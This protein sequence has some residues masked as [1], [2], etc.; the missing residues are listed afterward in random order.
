MMRGRWRR[1]ALAAFAAALAA[2]AAPLATAETAQVQGDLVASGPTR[3]LGSNS[4]RLD[5]TGLLLQD[6]PEDLAFQLEAPE[7]QVTLVAVQTQQVRSSLGVATAPVRGDENVVA[8]VRLGSPTVGFAAPAGATAPVIRIL[9][10]AAPLSVGLEGSRELAFGHT[11]P[12]APADRD[13][14][15][16]SSAVL[17]GN[18]TRPSGDPAYVAGLPA[19]SAWAEPFVAFLSGGVVSLPDGAEWPVGRWLNESAST[20]DPVSGSGR[21]VWDHHIAVVVGRGGALALPAGSEGWT[22]AA[23]GLAGTLDGDVAWT[24]VTADVWSQG[25]RLP[26]DPELFQLRG[27]LDLTARLSTTDEWSLAGQ[28]HFINVDGA[29]LPSAGV[30]AAA[31]GAG[32]LATLAL[33]FTEPGR[34]ALGL[35]LGRHAARL[36]KAAPLGNGSRQAILKVIHTQQPVRITELR[37]ATGLTKTALAYH[38][39][40]LLAYEVIQQA[41]GGSGRNTTFMLNSG[42]L[43]FR[44][45]GDDTPDEPRPDDGFLASEALAAVNGHP[46]R[47][48]IHA[49]VQEKGPIDFE[50]INRERV[51]RGEAPLVQS[52]ATHH[53]QLLEKAQALT[54]RR[55]GRRK[56]YVAAIDA[57]EARLE[58]YR[59]FLGQVRGT[60]LV[61]ALSAGPATAEQLLASLGPGAGRAERRTLERLH[62]F[63]LVEFDPS[64][65]AYHLA[66]FLEPLANRL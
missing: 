55:D 40:I 1:W 5:V 11:G 35:V 8:Q 32:L 44:V 45:F 28:A 43:A 63:G 58:Q 33:A 22:A 53:L 25:Q 34:A 52:S 60:A 64:Q 41:K 3:V 65:R 14:S 37:V 2:L 51:A 24:G 30:A 54:A 59:R 48:S 47:R 12:L 16:A 50:G 61:Q 62:A 7:A 17:A 42:S 66:G 29:V 31:A 6:G 26:A 13:T 27:T 57:R 21:Y 38:L 15:L 20:I 46:V 19:R 9:P 10:T 39:R 18:P 49:I 4:F 56:M 36:V 23:S